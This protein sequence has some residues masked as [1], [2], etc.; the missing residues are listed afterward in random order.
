MFEPRFWEM[1][2][3]A[4]HRL[5]F[6]SLNN[7]RHP[8]YSWPLHSNFAIFQNK[9]VSIN[10]DELKSTS[11]AIETVHNLCCNE[12][13][14][15]SELVAELSTLY[16][17]IRWA[18]TGPGPQLL[19]VLVRGGSAAEGKCLCGPLCENIL[20]VEHV[21][22]W[23]ESSFQNRTSDSLE[24]FSWGHISWFPQTTCPSCVTERAFLCHWKK[25][26]DYFV[27]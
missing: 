19:E 17:C 2:S 6:L 9:R 20:T 27:F 7:H 18:E 16:Q 24:S 13:K 5:Q 14:G 1:W 15:A 4:Y 25:M 11:K 8:V 22:L 3:W 21:K 10:K 26:R 23:S 12:N